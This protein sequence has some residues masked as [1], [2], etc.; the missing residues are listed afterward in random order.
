M[1]RAGGGRSRP[2]AHA[3]KNGPASRWFGTFYADPEAHTGIKT[4]PAEQH[5]SAWPLPSDT[6]QPSPSTQPGTLQRRRCLG[7][8]FGESRQNAFRSYLHFGENIC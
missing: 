2:A 4:G 7:L 5:I 8:G 1:E 3:R 6:R